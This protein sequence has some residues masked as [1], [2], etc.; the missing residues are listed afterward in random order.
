VVVYDRI[1]E[2][3]NLNKKSP[4][5]ETVNRALN[6]TLSRT[7]I[8]SFTTLIVILV[9]FLFGGEMIRGFSFALLIGILVGTYSSLF[10]SSNVVV[11]L[12]NA[13]KP[14]K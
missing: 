7:F 3:L 9:L 5:L 10:V 2:K 11:E 1:R 4:F 13:E 12:S 6:D 14:S 8:T